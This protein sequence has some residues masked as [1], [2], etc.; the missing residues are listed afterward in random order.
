M[1]RPDWPVYV[2]GWKCPIRR[3][4]SDRNFVFDAR[5][6]LPRHLRHYRIRAQRLELFKE[7]VERILVKVMGQS[8]RMGAT[9]G[10]LLDLYDLYAVR[11]RACGLFCKRV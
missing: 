6:V 4:L 7:D 8:D 2:R 5:S 9:K 10:Y 3:C 11:R 1:L